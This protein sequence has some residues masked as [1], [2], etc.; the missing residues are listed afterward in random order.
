MATEV[1]GWTL[2][3]LAQIFGGEVEGPADLRVVRPVPADSE[4]SEG[5]AFAE[6][7]TYLAQAAAGGAGAVLAPKGSPSTGKPTIFV[8]RPR[9]AFGR[10]LAMCAR[11]LPLNSGIHPTAIVDPGA[12][13]AESAQIGPYVV[14]ERGAVVGER[15]RVYAHSYVGENC[16]IGEK[17]VLYPRVVLYQDVTVGARVVLH[18][19]VVLG[20]DGFGFIWDGT[21]QVKIPQVGGVVLGD[22][23]EVGA[24]TTIDRAMS[25]ATTIGNDTKLD[26]L[27][28]VGHNTSIGSHTVIAGMTGVSGSCRI[29][30]RV[31]IAGQVAIPD[32]IK[33]GDDIVLAGRAAVMNDLSEKGSY[34]GMPA[35]PL[36]EAMRNL[37]LYTKLPELFRRVKKLERGGEE[38]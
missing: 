10:F 9:E 26:N 19:G 18:S 35:R 36:S 12:T 25:G 4:D 20:A 2:G 15:V 16:R 3:E 32:H 14:I 6:S 1:S 28:Q 37:M 21:R 38:E 8:D 34:F 24:N 22:D 5:L 13:V 29:G 30:D 33:I 7:E 11:P 23:V 17:S 27:I 31:T